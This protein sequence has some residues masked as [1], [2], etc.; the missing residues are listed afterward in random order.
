MNGT[1]IDIDNRYFPAEELNHNVKPYQALCR[2]IDRT[3]IKCDSVAD[4]GC[5]NG[6]FLQEFYKLHPKSRIYGC[7]Y[8]QWAIDACSEE[9]KP[10]VYQFDL[11]DPFLDTESFNLVICMEVAEHIDPS[12]CSV[13]LKNLRKKCNG[14]LVMTW[15][16]RGGI[17][18]RDND[19]HIQHLNPKSIQEYLQTMNTHGFELDVDMTRN[20]QREIQ[21]TH[22]F[23]WY[24]TESLG[25]FR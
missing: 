9:I 3:G 5:R 14:H 4:M 17:H 10:F 12:Y 16:S 15:S 22:E 24:W 7:D 6:L 1:K 19:G 21:Q 2:V 18:D 11:R 23:H 25:V 13:F 20:F 8:F